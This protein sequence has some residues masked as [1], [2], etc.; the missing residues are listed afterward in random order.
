MIRNWE[1]DK[2]KPDPFI[3]TEQCMSFCRFWFSTRIHV[4]PASKLAEVRRQLAEVDE[5]DARRGS[6][7]HEVPGSVFI[8][9]GLEIEEQQSVPFCVHA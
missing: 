5:E 9:S 4:S 7:L 8:R 6:I 2:S 3:H 1:R